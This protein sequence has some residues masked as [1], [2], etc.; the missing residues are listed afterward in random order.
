MSNDRWH[1]RTALGTPLARLATVGVA[2]DPGRRLRGAR[3]CVHAVTAASATQA[4]PSSTAA[5]IRV[6][7][8]LRRRRAP[9]PRDRLRDRPGQA[10]RLLR[11]GLRPAVQA[12]RGVHEA[13]PERDLGHQA[14]PVHEPHDRD[15]AAAVR[16]QP[17]R[18]DP[19]AV[20]GLARQG[21]AAQEPRRLRHGVRLGQVPARAARPEPGRRRTAPAAPARSTRWA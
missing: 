8:R 20:D 21:R 9:R 4:A 3:R 5:A 15:A 18:P 10:E 16:R 11:D 7:R 2:G 17:A 19:A 6:G 12:V 14:G 13:V 1:W